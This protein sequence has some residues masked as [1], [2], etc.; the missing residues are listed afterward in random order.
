M[1][2]AACLVLVMLF[3]TP[4]RAQY[5]TTITEQQLKNALLSNKVI[6]YVGLTHLVAGGVLIGLAIN[7]FNSPQYS[8]NSYGQPV[9]NELF[10]GTD[11]FILGCLIAGAGIPLLITG[12]VKS[13]NVNIELR[14]L[15]VP[16]S[17]SL[18][19]ITYRF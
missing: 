17:A 5:K 10:K 9:K 11:K 3:L 8:T 13:H 4:L 16:V 6:E 2:K 19:V 7:D 18:I 14:K 12:A 1:K 15:S